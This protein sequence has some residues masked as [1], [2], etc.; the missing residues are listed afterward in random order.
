MMIGLSSKL[1]R[2]IARCKYTICISYI[3]GNWLIYSRP[4]RNITSKFTKQLGPI[5]SKPL[6]NITV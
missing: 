4:Q 1:C 3:G 2:L 6:C 5:V